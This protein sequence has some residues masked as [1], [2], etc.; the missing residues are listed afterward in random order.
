MDTGEKLSSAIRQ[1]FHA[2]RQAHLR[3]FTNLSRIPALEHVES[4]EEIVALFNTPN[5]QEQATRAAA[6]LK[7]IEHELVHL[8]LDLLSEGL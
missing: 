4:H 1:A 2:T 5:H 6:D 8:Y 7:R 3:L